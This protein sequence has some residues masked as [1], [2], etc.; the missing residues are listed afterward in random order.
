M[1]CVYKIT[2]LI[3]NKS[4]IGSSTRVEKRWQQHKNDAFN[5]NNSKY[6]YPLYCAFRKYGIENFAFEIIKNDFSSIEEMETYEKEMIYFYNSLVPNG[7]NQT[8]NTTSNAIAQEN[9]QKYIKKIS[10][11]CALVDNNNNILKIYPSYH[12]AARDQG[13]DGDNMATIIQRICDGK[14]YSYN[15]LIFRCLNENNEVI[16]PIQQTRKRRSA[17]YGINK[18][19]PND[20]VFYDSISEAARQ[21]HIDRSS[22]QKCLSGSTRYSCV[23]GRIWKRKEE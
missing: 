1:N 14:I 11:K 20:I 2:N 3:N 19:N 8:D 7:Y 13:W 5:L 15:N 12:A 18:N 10:K 21:E 23:G 6:N 17:I 9:T 16:I 22:I 4:Y